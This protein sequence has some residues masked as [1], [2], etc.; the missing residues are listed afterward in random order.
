MLASGRRGQFVRSSTKVGD[1]IPFVVW[2]L[3]WLLGGVVALVLIAYDILL[4]HIDR[5]IGRDFTNLWVAGKLVWAGDAG[6]IFDVNCF[7]IA[8][9]DHLHLLALQ[10][11]SYPPTALFIAAPFALIPYYVALAVWTIA[12][13]AFFIWC[14]KPHLPNGFSPVLAALTSAATINIWNGHYGF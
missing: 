4:P 1:G 10:N 14:A 9:Y 11:Y 6:C 12:G 7:R 8:E 3:M 5:M 13:M 2:A